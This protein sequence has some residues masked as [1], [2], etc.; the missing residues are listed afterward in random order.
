M[1]RQQVSLGKREN[2]KG[3]PYIQSRKLPTYLTNLLTNELTNSIEQ[4][5]P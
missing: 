4:N 3:V 2:D 1:G 5:L